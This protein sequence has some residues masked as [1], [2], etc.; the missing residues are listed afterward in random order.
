MKITC[1]TQE[2]TSVNGTQDVSFLLDKTGDP[3]GKIG[4]IEVLKRYKIISR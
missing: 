2:T 4:G 1:G 3:T